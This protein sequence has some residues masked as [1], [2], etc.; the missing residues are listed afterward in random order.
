MLDGR[1]VVL[2]CGQVVLDGGQVVLDG[3]LDGG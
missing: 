1:Q 2:V 3:G